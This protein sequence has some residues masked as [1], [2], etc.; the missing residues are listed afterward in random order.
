M[1]KQGQCPQNRL[2]S[3]TSQLTSARTN[4]NLWH[5]EPILEVE[6]AAVVEENESKNSLGGNLL[7][8]QT[9]PLHDGTVSRGPE[10][11]GT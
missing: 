1:Q 3:I 7:T 5:I 8:P 11:P 9:K 2:I 6:A 4:V 10:T